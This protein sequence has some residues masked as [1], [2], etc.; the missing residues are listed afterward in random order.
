MMRRVSIVLFLVLL[1]SAAAAQSPTATPGSCC[2]IGVS[3]GCQD[4][5][6][7]GCVC[8]F[9]SYC[10]DTKWDYQCSQE[11]QGVNYGL[12]S[13][14]CSCPPTATPTITN[15]PTIT[16][17][18]TDTPTETPT[19]AT[20]TPTDTPTETPTPPETSTP[21]ETPSPTITPTAQVQVYVDP[22]LQTVLT[23]GSVDVNIRVN[24]IGATA[25]GGA[26]FLQYD[27][28]LLGFSGGSNDTAL[29]GF[30][31]NAEPMVQPTPGNIVSLSV[32][33]GSV[34]GTTRLVSS[35]AFTA[36]ANG[37]ANLTL[38]FV[39]GMQETQFYG[40]CSPSMVALDTVRLDGVV[41]IGGTPTAV[42]TATPT[43]TTT[44]TP[45]TETPTQ[46]PSP[47]SI[48]RCNTNADCPTGPNPIG[49][50]GWSCL[51]TVAAT[52]TPTV[53][54]TPSLT[55]TRTETPTPS[56]TPIPT[57]WCAS[58][59]NQPCQQGPLVCDPPCTPVADTI[60][61]VTG[62]TQP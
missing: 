3:P 2:A 22:A 9:D 27:P 13:C 47:T 59:S 4:L 8:N 44:A 39:A 16:E 34:T 6:C 48:G 43:D 52:F 24:I 19:A 1:A 23:G 12:G 38:L 5:T 26:V 28:T 41:Q 60:C 51:P 7:Q 10:C 62:C 37:T 58:F 57:N 40:P 32:G 30:S 61:T 46:T 53:T 49:G 29:W 54:R 15:T 42:P 11:A 36:L 21:T 31:T 35:L 17:T 14:T 55:P 18:P 33:A 20:N 50:I 56:S 25:C 45:P